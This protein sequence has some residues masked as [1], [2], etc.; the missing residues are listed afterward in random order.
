LVGKYGPYLKIGKNNFKL[1]K[2]VEPS[3]LTLAECLTIAENQP[4]KAKRP[5]K[6]KK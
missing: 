6:G 3:A 4:A 1:P 5:F 2:D